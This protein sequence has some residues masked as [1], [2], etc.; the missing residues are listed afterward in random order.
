MKRAPF[1]FTAGRLFFVSTLALE[2]QTNVRV[3]TYNIHRDIGASDSNISLQP[4]LA[5]V[6]LPPLKPG[7]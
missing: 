3:V 2:A 7:A 1:L 4:A 6:G 5:K